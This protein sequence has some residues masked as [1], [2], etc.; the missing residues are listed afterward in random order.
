MADDLRAFGIPEDEI[1]AALGPAPEGAADVGV[2]DLNWASLLAFLAAETLWRP[3]YVVGFSAVLTVWQG[4]DYCQLDV[5][6]RRRG[7]DDP[8]G[9]IWR[10][11][12]HMEAAALPILNRGAGS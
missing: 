7:I 5:M 12:Q 8:D 6:L 10:D 2:W 4:L 3:T 9:R 11:I 1:A